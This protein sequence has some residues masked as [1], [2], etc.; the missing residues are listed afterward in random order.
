MSATYVTASVGGTSD[1]DAQQQQQQQQQ[2]QHQHQQ[3]KQQSPKSDD[4]AVQSLEA[5]EPAGSLSTTRVADQP[6]FESDH[7]LSFADLPPD[8]A[9]LRFSEYPNQHPGHLPTIYPRQQ[10]Q[11]DNN[12]HDDVNV[13]DNLDKTTHSRKSLNV[14]AFLQNNITAPVIVHQPPDITQPPLA[15]PDADALD[16]SYTQTSQRQTSVSPARITARRPSPGLA[17]RLKAL[18]FGSSNSQKETQSAAALRAEAIGRLDEEQLRQLDQGH[19]AGSEAPIVERRGRPWKGALVR[20]PSKA[21]LKGLKFRSG[22]RSPSLV[23][24]S[25]AEAAVSSAAAVTSEVPEGPELLPEIDT[26]PDLTMDTN[27]FRLPDH[28]NGNGTKCQPETRQ[29]HLDRDSTIM[30]PTTPDDERP[31]PPPKDSPPL[32]SATTPATD[33]SQE[34]HFNPLGLQRPGS[35]YTLSRASFSN[36]LAQLTSLQLPDANSLSEKVAAISTAQ[37]AA[38]ALI[39][40]AEQIRNWISKAS[41]VISGLDS[42]DDVEWSAAGGRE[43]LEEVENAISRFESLIK[44]YLSAIEALNNRPDIG[45]VAPEDLARTVMQMEAITKEWANIHVTLNSVKGQVEIAMEWEE[46]WNMVLGDIQ[47]EMDELCRL[48][49]EMEERR[50]KSM[51]AVANSQDNVDIGDLETIVEETPPAATR[52]QAAKSHRFSLPAF[53]ASPSS[54]GVPNLTQDDSSLLALFAR[55]QPLRASLDFL[56]M[57]LSVFAARA[58][59]T[60]PSA[61]EE[62]EMRREDL[63]NS[64]KKLEKDAENLR[65]ELGEDRWILVFRG[66]ARQA[67]KMYESVERSVAKIK[68]CV[69]AGL[70]LTNPALMCKK[71]ESYEAKKTHYSPAIERVLS[72]IDR[73]IKDRLTVNGEIVRLHTELQTKWDEMRDRMREMDLCLDELTMD[74]KGQAL[75]DSISTMLSNDMSGLGSGH[76]TPQSSPPSSVIMSGL[77]LET[78]TSKILNKRRSVSGN[79]SGL[80]MP[81]NR[82][83]MSAVAPSQQQPRKP[84]SRLSTTGGLGRDNSLTPMAKPRSST[85]R[86]SNNPI[87]SRPRWNSSVNG[88]DTGHNFKPLA[89]EPQ[90]TPSPR[91]SATKMPLRSPLSG[92]AGSASPMPDA[93]PSKPPSSHS[94]YSFRERLTSPGPYSQQATAASRMNQARL[95]AQSSST[96]L[97]NRRSS[98]QPPGRPTVDAPLGTSPARPASSMATTNPRRTS[99]LPQSSGSMG[100]AR[101]GVVRST[102]VSGRNTPSTQRAPF[103][104]SQTEKPMDAKPRWKF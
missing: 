61:A 92:R 69:D 22:K 60:F 2:H 51:L 64:Y 15:C 58:E 78:P 104:K 32:S 95:T 8:L 80:P 67:Q 46:L 26:V 56:P 83:S 41:E 24:P 36:Q 57:R 77:G 21:S 40:A 54:P 75:R 79:A 4:N 23:S 5:P 86:P 76:E 99:A 48:V 17:A 45:S 3:Q 47:N 88:V 93:T 84:I 49:F 16:D 100:L 68:E 72:I 12:K 87:P 43:G 19:Q 7:G 33:F 37:S 103:R 102:S 55:M 85:T 101:D 96:A 94:R 30:S 98:L 39:G 9:E 81:T 25:D 59:K 50:H 10:Q 91:S 89:V 18:G 20:I 65:K 70:N 63:D 97:G 6:P 62:L 35:I 34:I 90:S 14:A 11:P 1:P 31:P 13:N 27:K 82:R 52:L 66:A 38:R 74:D 28:S 73:G 53:P 42:D 29:Q 44:V 71:I